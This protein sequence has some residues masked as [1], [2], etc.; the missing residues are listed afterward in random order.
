MCFFLIHVFFKINLFL[1]L[2]FLLVSAIHH[3]ESATGIHISPPSRTFL[4]PPTLLGC[5]RAAVWAPCVTQQ[6]PCFTHGCIHVSVLLCR[7]PPSPS[8]SVSTGERAFKEIIKVK[9][10]HKGGA[11]VHRGWCP[12]KKTRRPQGCVCSGQAVWAHCE[13]VAVFRAKSKAAGETLP[14]LWFGFPP[15][16]LWKNEFLFFLKPLLSLC[17][18]LLWKL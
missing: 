9:W 17:G 2:F 13:K 16:E 7:V 6:V 5:H 10:G 4:P 18:I 14:R 15:P 3:H 12:H 8:P 1:F 11:L